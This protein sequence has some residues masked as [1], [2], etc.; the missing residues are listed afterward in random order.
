MTTTHLDVLGMGKVTVQAVIPADDAVASGVNRRSRDWDW[1][2]GP[3]RYARFHHPVRMELLERTERGAHI[4]ILFPDDLERTP[5]RDH[6][7]DQLR[8]EPSHLPGIKAAK[9]PPH[10][11]DWTVLVGEI[12][13]E[14]NKTIEDL[15]GRPDVAA[16]T[17]TNRVM[18]QRAKQNTYRLGAGVVTQ[19]PRKHQHWTPDA[20]RQHSGQHRRNSYEGSQLCQSSNLQ[21]DSQGV[22]SRAHKANRGIFK[23]VQQMLINYLYKFQS[24]TRAFNRFRQNW[25]GASQRTQSSPR[26]WLENPS[27]PRTRR[28]LGR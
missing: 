25:V 19:K 15:V 10:K 9:T 7:A 1:F 12:I 24:I 22:E 26:C 5:K 20:A 18:P 11:V 3:A 2:P 28:F 23:W 8:N 13:K 27:A 16:K 21:H 17:P 6:L 4:R 14:A